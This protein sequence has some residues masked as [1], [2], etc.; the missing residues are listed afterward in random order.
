[1]RNGLQAN[2]LCAAATSSISMAQHPLPLPA[3]YHALEGSSPAF[4]YTT[5]PPAPGTAAR[6]GVAASDAKAFEMTPPSS[7]ATVNHAGTAERRPLEG[8]ADENASPQVR[9]YSKLNYLPSS[10]IWIVSLC[11]RSTPKL[12]T[13]DA[14][15]A[16]R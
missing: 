4:C 16:K 11:D 6:L 5:T 14:S 8:P 9:T 2:K 7:A 1:M 12:W 15:R 13:R 3:A 10:S